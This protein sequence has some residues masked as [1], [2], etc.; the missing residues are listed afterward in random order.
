MLAGLLLAALPVCAAISGVVVNGTTGKPEAGITV[1]L[2]KMGPKGPQPA[3]QVKADAQ[4][5]FKVDQSVDGPTLV[6]ATLDG[7]TYNHVLVP[8]TP[9]EG[10]NLEVYNASKQPGAAK[11]TKHMLLFEPTGQQL[12]VN[13]AFIVSNTG[14][15]AWNDPADG[16][17]HIFLPR[18]LDGQA[19]ISATPPGG[20]PLQQVAEKTGQPDVFK[21]NF[22]MRPGETRVDVSY[23][24]PYKEGE[25]YAG[26]IPSKDDNTYL[27]VPEGVTMQADNLNDMG[28]EPRTKAHIY[29]LKGTDYKIQLTGTVSERNTDS[30]ASGADT[31]GQ[32]P[33][34]EIMPRLYTQIKLIL[35]LAFG[36]LALGFILLY[37]MPGL[38]EGKPAK[39]TNA[40]DRR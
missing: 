9:S 10:I 29:G 2:L 35:P 1:T 3:G 16:T 26:K 12:V 30:G 21:I 7:V 11:V 28:Q 25:A 17:L 23:S 18:T 34:Q 13:E 5:R 38:P 15:T 33:V 6:R 40:R 32:P 37:R 4:G 19:Q 39:E 27:I 31:S 22:P 8:G 14:K 24:L 36:I 20:Q